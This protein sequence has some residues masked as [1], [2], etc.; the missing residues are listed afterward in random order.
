MKSIYRVYYRFVFAGQSYLGV[1]VAY[2]LNS[3]AAKEL[4]RDELTPRYGR[5]EVTTVSEGSCP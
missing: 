4:C 3:G 2:A 1:Y 5:I